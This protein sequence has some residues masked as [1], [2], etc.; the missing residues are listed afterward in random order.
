VSADPARAPE[1]EAPMLEQWTFPPDPGFAGRTIMRRLLRNI[2]EGRT[3]GDS[4]TLADA[5]VVD[6]IR[7]R[8][9][10]AED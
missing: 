5:A 1:I 3:P 4:S 7:A 10:Q 9:G 6:T 8:S 2:A